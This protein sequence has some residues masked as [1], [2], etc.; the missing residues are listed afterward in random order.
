MGAAVGEAR[1]NMCIW[2]GCGGWGVGESVEGRGVGDR[3]L[4]TEVEVE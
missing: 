4:F 1:R 3:E 2:G